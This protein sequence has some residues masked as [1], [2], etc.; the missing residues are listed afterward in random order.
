MSRLALGVT[1]ALLGVS[2]LILFSSFDIFYE[3][4]ICEPFLETES[5]GLVQIGK[6]INRGSFSLVLEGYAVESHMNVAVKLGMTP[7]ANTER[8][9]ELLNKLNGSSAFPFIYGAGVTRCEKRISK[10]AVYY[11]YIVMERLG[12]PVSSLIAKIPDRTERI[13]LAAKIADNVLTGVSELHSIGYLM[14][15]LYSENVLLTSNDQDNAH[16]VK[17]IDFGEV[18]NRDTPRLYNQINSCYTSVRE[19]QGLPLSQRDDLERVVYLI[20]SIV[21]EQL[22]WQNLVISDRKLFKEVSVWGTLAASYPAS[23]ATLL[24]YARHKLSRGAP[25]DLDYC[26]SLLSD[27]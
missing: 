5:I 11:P 17:L 2:A 18:V 10:R 20:M 8:D 25:I 23:L 13:K 15:D 22:P 27:M 16:S 26:R 24:R 21:D 14:H 9:V 12:S 7:L 1:L 19:D 3:P 4:G 6:M